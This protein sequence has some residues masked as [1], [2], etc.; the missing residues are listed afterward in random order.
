MNQEI[1]IAALRKAAQEATP[2]PWERSARP[3]GPFWHISSD[4][5]VGG[6]RCVSGKQAV[7]AVHATNKRVTPVYAAMFEA[8]AR[9]IA[10][11][12]PA[13]I[14]AL[15]DRLEQAEKD[16]ARYR[17]LRNEAWGCGQLSKEGAPHVVKFRSTDMRGGMTELAEEALDSAVD[18]AMQGEGK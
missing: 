2:G 4:Y 9:H 12:N 18:A 7:A 13:A 6:E 8:N 10:A 16:A 15:L 11:A 1:D 14:L 5:T 17:W 3:S